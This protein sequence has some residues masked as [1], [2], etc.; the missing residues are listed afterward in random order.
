MAIQDLPK[1]IGDLVG[2]NPRG[3]NTAMTKAEL[4]TLLENIQ[5]NVGMKAILMLGLNSGMSLKEALDL[6]TK[7][8]LYNEYAVLVWDAAKNRYR[9][10]YLPNDVMDAL[11]NFQD[12]HKRI[13]SDRLFDTG[14][15]TITDSLAEITKRTILKQKTWKSVR[16]TWASLAFQ[17]GML[18]K[19]MAESSGLTETTLSGD[20]T[21]AKP[22]NGKDNKNMNLLEGIL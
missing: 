9:K 10:I 2:G 4:R 21:I 16:R 15:R 19:D 13:L 17:K 22:T 8:I 6:R 20:I 5:G 12:H 3:D 11:K 18:I 14:E 1:Q 7:D